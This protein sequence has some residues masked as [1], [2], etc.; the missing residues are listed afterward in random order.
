[1]TK[2]LPG[3][4]VES[5]DKTQVFFRLYDKV[6]SPKGMVL[7]IHG[8]VEHS[9]R[10]DAFSRYLNKNGFVVLTYDQRSHGQTV[11]VAED[12]GKYRGDLFEDCVCDAMFFA[13]LLNEKYKLPLI[14]LG[15][16]YGS[17]VLQR[18]IERYKNYSGAVFVGSAC[19]AKSFE[20]NFGLFVAKLTKF[21]FGKDA[22]AK[23]IYKSSFKNYEKNFEDGN[24]LTRDT[25]I[26]E[27]YKNDP[28]C[29]QICS[30]NFYYSFFKN[31]KLTYKKEALSQIEKDKPILILS[32]TKDPVGKFGKLV[33]KLENQYKSLGVKDVQMKLF[34]EG[35]HEI[36]NETNR[37]E[38]WQTVVDFLNKICVKKS[39]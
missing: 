31:L 15:H 21:F 7:L 18:V 9:A 38:V 39:K 5:F 16:S 3:K 20:V 33:V 14:F 23:L 29:Q 25:K 2:I 36:L 6:E 8:M 34:N 24:W 32:G 30:A 10:Y 37:D 27:A 19:M 11:K 28:Y 26:F 13:N 1:M 4:Y 12:V 17:F 22:K 35:R